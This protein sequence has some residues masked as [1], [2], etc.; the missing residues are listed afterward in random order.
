M[1]SPPAETQSPPIGNFLETVLPPRCIRDVRVLV[2]FPYHF[3]DGCARDT[4]ENRMRK[5]NLVDKR[6]QGKTERHLHRRRKGGLGPLDFEIFSKNRL[7][8]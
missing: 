7:F 2:G 5:N 3:C 8:S 6:S 4:E 1:S